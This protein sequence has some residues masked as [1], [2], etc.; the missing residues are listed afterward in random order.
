MLGPV[1]SITGQHPLQ[2]AVS[3]YWSASDAQQAK[4]TIAYENALAK[5]SSNPDGTIT[6]PAG[7][8]GP[9]PTIM[10]G[11]LNFAQAG[12]LDGALLTGR[13]FYQTDYT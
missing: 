12:G 1:R 7:G 3:A 8:Y 4:W 9:L 13:Q 6:V 11:L 2:A 5:A 10:S